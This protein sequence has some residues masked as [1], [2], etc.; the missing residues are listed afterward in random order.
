MG[1]GSAEPVQVLRDGE[2]NL[3]NL[4]TG[5]GIP[6]MDD[7]GKSLQKTRE[8]GRAFF[9]FALRA[10]E[11]AYGEDKFKNGEGKG[12]FWIPLFADGFPQLL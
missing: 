8:K 10:L 7:Y 3:Q 4:L 5:E 12:H 11:Y 2:S 6:A 9:A 1:V